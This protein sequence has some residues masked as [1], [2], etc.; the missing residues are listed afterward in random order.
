MMEKIN[1]YIFRGYDIRGI[2]PTEINEEVAILLGKAFGSKVREN[3]ET[4]CIIGH[5]NRLSSE[6]LEKA[7]ISGIV[8]TGVDVISLGLCTTPMYYFACLHENIPAGIMITASHNPKNENG[9]KVALKL[10]ENLKGQEIQDLYQFL[11]KEEFVEGTGTVSKLNIK[12][13]Y[14]N[15]IMKGLSFGNRRVK[16]VIDCG[17]GTTSPFAKEL[18]QKFPI[19]VIPLYDVS[20]GTFPHHH[21]DPSVEDNLEDL[22]K[23]VIE[24][25]ADVG[26]AFDG[27]GDRVGI[28]S[29][30]GRFIPMDQYMIIMIQNIIGTVRK[31]AF[32]Y[33]VKCS[34][35]LRDEIIKLGA[36]PIEYRTGN[37][38]TKKGVHDL[39]LD[40]GGEFSGHIYFRDRFLGFDSGLYAGLR[41]VEV[42]SK[43]KE[44]IEE[45]LEG[46]S[47]YVETPEIKIPM[48]DHKKF[49]VIQKLE[50]FCRKQGYSFHTIDGIKVLL[51][52]GFALIRVSNTGPNITARFE[53]KDEETLTKRKGYF[54]DLLKQIEKKC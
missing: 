23:K 20:D 29:N 53:A 28:I 54:L 8:S 25:Q 11:L 14:F 34:N 52:D 10:G 26:L 4:K 22:K 32:L 47:T 49:I 9:F 48:E 19:E 7:L 50:E 5:D 35:A 30:K 16:V 37:S 3:Q 2:Y 33:D 42:L 44:S 43:R 18:Y 13:D 39:D 6:S 38:Y 21:P 36:K 17:N 24:E 45:L 27:D 41:L 12:D 15:A 31:K 51:D 1:P 46:I 40:F